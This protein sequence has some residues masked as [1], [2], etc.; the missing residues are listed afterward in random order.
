MTA[1]DDEL[2][3]LLRDRAVPPGPPASRADAVLRRARTRR[4]RRTALACGAAGLAALAVAATPALRSRPGPEA[5]GAAPA[6]AGSVPAYP[7]RSGLTQVRNVVAADRTFTVGVERGACQSRATGVAW[8]AGGSW[9]LAVWHPGD[10][11]ASRR[12]CVD[13]LIR[14][15]LHVPLPERY[16]GQPVVDEASG[17]PVLVNGGPGFRMPS[18]LPPGYAYGP[19]GPTALELYGPA[20]PIELREGGSEVGVVHDTPGWPYDVLD[21]PAI[22]DRTGVLIRFRNDGGNTML[23]WV[24]DAG[25][26]FALQVLS[27]KPDPEELVKIARSIH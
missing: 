3:E 19:G 12:T 20:G 8:L 9:H 21:R 26:G 4:R 17:A 5:G 13:V 25:H 2:R 6:A 27:T 24:D 1:I 23:V 18:Y 14:D 22:G 15:T 7:P 11:R 16:A 10:P